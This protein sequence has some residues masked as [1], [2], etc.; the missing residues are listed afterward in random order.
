VHTNAFLLT[1]GAILTQNPIGGLRT[2]CLT[3]L[4]TT[5]PKEPFMKWGPIK[6]IRK[7][8]KIKYI[9]VATNYVTHWVKAKDLK[10][11]L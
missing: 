1:I 3:K 8:I 9:L 2:K 7:L 6:P 4:I 11:I 10:P 5:L